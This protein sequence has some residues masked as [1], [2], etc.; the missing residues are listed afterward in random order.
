VRESLKIFKGSQCVVKEL[1][2]W[3]KKINIRR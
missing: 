2:C 3:K 1:L